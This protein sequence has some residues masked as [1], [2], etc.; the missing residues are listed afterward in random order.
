MAGRRFFEASQLHE[1]AALFG[2]GSG[3]EAVPGAVL[4]LDRDQ[5]LVDGDVGAELVERGLQVAPHLV[6]PSQEAMTSRE[7]A[8][9]VV[10]SG[11][12]LGDLFRDRPRLLERRDRVGQPA[13]LAQRATEVVGDRADLVARGD[14]GWIRRPVRARLLD[15][16]PVLL[17][18]GLELTRELEAPSGVLVG[19]VALHRD[20][21]PREHAR[22]K[23]LEQ[24]DRLEMA[25]PRLERIPHDQQRPARFV[26]CAHQSDASLGIVGTRGHQRSPASPPPREPRRRRLASGLRRRAVS[27]AGYALPRDGSRPRAAT[28]TP[29]PARSAARSRVGALPRPAWG[30]P[31]GSACWRAA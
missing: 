3:V 30:A 26:E 24:R 31:A 21:A 19:V 18:G 13:H 5:L 7:V 22:G 27:P 29:M 25:L 14:V 28:T 6:H 1:H 16:D 15:P 9:V 12:A 11:V 23:R 17:D 4:G 8:S 10:V 20:L 2:Q